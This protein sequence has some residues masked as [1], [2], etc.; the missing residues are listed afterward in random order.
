M[1]IAVGTQLGEVYVLEFSTGRV[2]ARFTGMMNN[3]SMMMKPIFFIELL[4]IQ[5][6][7][8]VFPNLQDLMHNLPSTPRSNK[9]RSAF[10]QVNSPPSSTT[11]VSCKLVFGMQDACYYFSSSNNRCEEVLPAHRVIVNRHR[12]SQRRVQDNIVQFVSV[13]HHT[14]DEAS[15]MGSEV[16]VWEWNC[17]SE[18]VESCL[19]LKTG[20]QTPSILNTINVIDQ[21]VFVCHGCVVHF[22]RN[23]DGLEIHRLVCGDNTVPQ[24]QVFI[25]RLDV[26]LAGNRILFLLNSGRAFTLYRGIRTQVSLPHDALIQDQYLTE[27]GTCGVF[28]LAGKSPTIHFQDWHSLDRERLVTLCQAQGAKRMP[29]TL[30]KRIKYWLF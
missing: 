10:H 29:D 26:S 20:A 13:F 11:S 30:L 25:E 24:P 4:S 28:L 18:D 5:F 8:T 16:T 3:A 2:L 19:E 23:N 1:F 14:R 27:D 7:L 9:Q 15:F 21:L 17:S 22:Y 12:K 6:E